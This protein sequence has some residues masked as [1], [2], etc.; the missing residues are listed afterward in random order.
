[1]IFFNSFLSTIPQKALKTSPHLPLS[2]LWPDCGSPI[3]MINSGGVC[4]GP[5]G[6]RYT[7]SLLS[8]TDRDTSQVQGTM[9]KAGERRG[10]GRALKDME[11]LVLLLKTYRAS[12]AMPP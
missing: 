12:T 9:W 4:V 2:L 10:A 6:W 8:I 7:G 11:D 1:M 3:S 5:W